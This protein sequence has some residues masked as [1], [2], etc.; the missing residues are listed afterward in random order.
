MDITLPIWTNEMDL[1]NIKQILYVSFQGSQ[2]IK[3]YRSNFRSIQQTICRI[4]DEDYASREVKKNMSYI[5][6][7]Y[8]S[9]VVKNKICLY[10]MNIKL[11]K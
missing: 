11:P 2:N 6:R 1:S 3:I 8:A 9:K 10:K 5:N 7:Y 4:S